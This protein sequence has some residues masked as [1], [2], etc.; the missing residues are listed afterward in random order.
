MIALFIRELRIKNFGRF[1]EKNIKLEGGINLIYGDNEAG[2]T[3]IHTF[4]KGMF[5]GIIKQ[6]GRVT[7]EDVYTRYLPW[8]RQS[9]FNG[10]M[11]IEVE[12]RVYRIHR[13]F[14]K[15]SKEYQVVDMTTGREIEFKNIFGEHIGEIFT[16]ANYR[17]TISIEQTKIATNKDLVSQVQNYIA[18]LSTSKNSEVNVQNAIYKLE[19][20]KKEIEKRNTKERL[21]ELEQ[22]L[23]GNRVHNKRIDNLTKVLFQLDIKRDDSIA[24][25]EREEKIKDKLLKINNKV[26]EISREMIENN[27]DIQD[28]E[29]R[30]KEIQEKGV[31]EKVTKEFKAKGKRCS[32]Q[33]FIIYL[34]LLAIGSLFVLSFVENMNER[35]GI[36]IGMFVM[37]T[38]IY[39][40][41]F[42]KRKDNLE[43]KQLKDNHHVI[44]TLPGQLEG[45]NDIDYK[46]L[47]NELDEEKKTLEEALNRLQLQYSKKEYEE[48][49][50]RRQQIRWELKQLDEKIIDADQK[51]REHEE[52]IE[53]IA[54]EEKDL[55]AIYVSITSI[56]NLS[57]HIHDG[58]G[59]H[60][61]KLVSNLVKDVT[62]GKY[63]EVR[64][65]EKLNIKVLSDHEFVEFEKLSVGTIE[66]IYLALRI[67]ISEL[68]FGELSVPLILD[69]SFVYYDSKRLKNTLDQLTNNTKRQIILF[70]C[71]KREQN[72]LDELGIDYNY[73]KL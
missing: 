64:I 12:D 21:Q 3:T 48:V 53:K 33:S 25:I 34:I 29:K 17:N 60:L 68:I 4:I 38:F 71:Q 72:T 13:N 41:Y 20:K 65:D 62:N 66:Q 8:D 67:G 43:S 24:L 42:R 31:E 49:E 6:R 39:I 32:K 40:I 10:S 14:H 1:H 23:E 54:E 5:F 30:E 28:K 56:K 61:N 35:I 51:E 69:D 19:I 57:I 11:D 46:K 2:K 63:K 18:N 26:I 73:I 27:K 9:Q 70:T 47:M 45:K 59:S 22:E 15:D 36:I 50:L 44:C 37:M 58:F 55:R 52:L 16:E 7:K